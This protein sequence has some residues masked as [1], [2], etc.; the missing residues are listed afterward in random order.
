M[1]GVNLIPKQAVQLKDWEERLAGS[2]PSV[3]LVHSE[4]LARSEGHAPGALNKLGVEEGAQHIFVL[5][6][7]TT[8]HEYEPE[9]IEALRKVVGEPSQFFAV[10]YTDEGLLRRVLAVLLRHEGEGR[11]VVE[12]EQGNLTLL[13]DFLETAEAG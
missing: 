13:E 11:V 7:P 10:D 12:D 8:I 1:R 5:D 6:R 4:I 3:W 9:E 2:F